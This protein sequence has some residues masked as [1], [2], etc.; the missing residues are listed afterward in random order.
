LSIKPAGSCRRAFSWSAGVFVWHGQ[1][2]FTRHFAAAFAGHR[3]PRSTKPFLQRALRYG[4]RVEH[5]KLR[6]SSPNEDVADNKR[7]ALIRKTEQC[8]SIRSRRMTFAFVG[9]VAITIIVGLSAA[10]AQ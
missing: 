10:M 4:A 2:L 7:L 8:G 9:I 1:R 6:K 5:G 3:P